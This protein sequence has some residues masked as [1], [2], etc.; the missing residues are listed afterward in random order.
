VTNALIADIF[1]CRLC[2]SLDV[3]LGQLFDLLEFERFDDGFQ[4]LDL[5]VN[6]ESRG[7]L[8]LKA[9]RSACSLSNNIKAMQA[10]FSCSLK[11]LKR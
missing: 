10:S 9:K 5:K 3:E 1:D 8:Q 6:S 11:W 7:F 4:S 2:S